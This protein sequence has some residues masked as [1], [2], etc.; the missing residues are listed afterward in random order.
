[1][2]LIPVPQTVGP[3]V[4]GGQQYSEEPQ[5]SCVLIVVIKCYLKSFLYC[6]IRLNCKAPTINRDHKA[7]PFFKQ[8]QQ[9]VWTGLFEQSEEQGGI[10]PFDPSFKWGS[11]TDAMKI[12]GIA[13]N[14]GLASLA[15]YQ[16][17]FTFNKE[18]SISINLIW[19]KI[20]LDYGL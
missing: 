13:L 16:P 1:M 14:H 5:V 2:G 10:S 11:K 7:R 4:C 9:N 6:K 15:W 3:P 8:M 19:K 17:A 20:W 12:C 18:K